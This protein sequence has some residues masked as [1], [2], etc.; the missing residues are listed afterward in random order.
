M[1]KEPT[2]ITLTSENAL[3]FLLKYVELSQGKG[4]FLIAE[5]DLLKRC[6][7]VLLHSGI[8]KDISKEKAKDLVIQAIN[9]GQAHGDYTLNDASLLFNTINFINSGIKLN[10]QPKVEEP[11]IV[12]DGKIEEAETQEN[13]DD[14]DCDLS[15]LSQPVPL[16]PKMI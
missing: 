16:K 15:E 9:K 2:V 12:G 6:F 8:D 7:D 3:P 5:A 11:A 14:D 10:V 4:T 13:D 1:S